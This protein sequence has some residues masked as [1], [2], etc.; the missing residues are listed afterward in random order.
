MASWSFFCNW[1]G[2]PFETNDPS[3]RFDRQRCGRDFARRHLTVTKVTGPTPRQGQILAVLRQQRPAWVTVQALART[4][5]GLDGPAE[6]RAIQQTVSRLRLTWEVHGLAIET[7]EY[8]GR[9]LGGYRLVRDIE[10]PTM[11]V[12]S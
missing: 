1:C 12:A 5:Y 8:H 4:V 7:R 10:Q 9:N 2:Q 6:R 11:V 3:R